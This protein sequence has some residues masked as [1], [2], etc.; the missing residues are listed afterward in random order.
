MTEADNLEL[1]CIITDYQSFTR[2]IRNI[3]DEVFL[4]EQQI[5]REDEIDD[6]DILCQHA[7]AFENELPV[8]TGRLDS[9]KGGKVGRVAVLSTHRRGG[10]GSLIMQAFEQYARQ[11]DLA[12]LW[13]HAQKSA[14][15]FYLSLDY[16]IVG[17]EF[18]EAGIPHVV[19]EKRFL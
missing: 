10:V 15:P 11:Q 7:L 16:Q 5:R 1:R 12:R 13:F 3:R 8:G 19:M 14:V 2:E 18:F 4:L 9:E 6:R 17:D